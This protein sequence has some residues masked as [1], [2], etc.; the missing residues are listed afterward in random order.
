LIFGGVYWQYFEEL[1][2][3]KASSSPL[4]LN[5][6]YYI[7]TNTANGPVLNELQDKNSLKVGDK[8]VVR[9][10]LKT[11]RDL[12]YVHLKDMRPSGTE[13]VNVLSQFKY[14]NGLGYY[15]ST[16]DLASHFFIDILRKG[17]YVFE[18]TVFATHSGNFSSGISTIQCMY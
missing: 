16:K 12:E 4:T 11:D 8:V 14:G 2:K 7:Q 9:I 1:D 3:I 13:P 15:E 5:K 10:L 18:Y 6:K 17:S